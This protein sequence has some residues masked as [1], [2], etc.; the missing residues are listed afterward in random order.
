MMSLVKYSAWPLTNPATLSHMVPRPQFCTFPSLNNVQ[1]CTQPSLSSLKPLHISSVEKFGLS[2]NLGRRVTECRA[3]EADRSRPLELNIE[4]NGEGERIEATQRVKIGLYFATWWALNVVFN[5][6]NKKVLNAFP[7]PWLISTLSLAAGSLMMLISWA[8]RVA[9]VPKVN[10]EFWKALFP[11]AVAHTIGHVAATVSMSKVAVSFT[12]IIKSGEPAFS[13]LVSRFLLGEAFPV[14]VYLS[15]VPIIGGCAL[16]AVTELNFNMIGFM[17]AMISNLAFVF[18]NIFSKKGM[19]GMSVSGM[20]YYACLSILSLLILTPLAIAVEGPKLWAAGWQEALSQIGPNFVWWVAAQS[21]FYHLYNQVSYMSLDQISP[22]TFSI[23]NTMKRISVIVS[24][25]LIFHTPI[26]PVNALGAA[27]AILGTFLYSQEDNAMG[28]CGYK[29]GLV[30]EI[31]LFLF[32]CSLLPISLG[33]DPSPPFLFGTASSSYQYEGAYSSDGKGLSNWDVFSHTAGSIDDGSNGD[34]SVDQY[35]RYQE[36]IDLMEAMKVNSYRFSISWARILPQGRF[37]E[38]NLAGINYYNRLI[39]ALLLK[40]IQPF[41]TLFHFDI[42]QE[43]EDRYGAWLSPQSQEDFQFFADICFKFFGDRVKYWVTFNEPNYIIS[44]AYREGTFPPC[45]CSGIFGNCS[46]GDSE[47]EP[48]V[49]AHNMILSH[50]AAVDLYRNKYQNEQGGKI[51]IVL[52]CDSF[53]PLS[54]STSDKLATER[55]QSFSINWILDPILFGKYPKEMEMILGTIL[56]KFSSNDKVKLRRGLDFIGINHYASYYVRDCL[57]SVCG[58]GIGVSRTEGSYELTVL[59]N[60]VPIGELTPFEWLNVHPEGM[61]KIVIYLKDRYNN[62]PMFIAENGYGT[63][64]DPNVTEKEYL[65]DYKRIEFMS[66]HLD[67]LMAAIREGA[68]VRGYFVWSLLDNFEWKYGFTVR[69]GLYHVDFSTLKRTPKLSASWYKFFIEKYIAD[70][71]KRNILRK[72][73]EENNTSTS[74]PIQQ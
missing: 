12:H 22:L 57:S 24:S 74:Y 25:I 31:M 72:T 9:D 50:A 26:Q 21:V 27:I 42:P 67:N 4:L 52:H 36:D 70:N 18:R 62:T 61:K 46:E 56:P 48:F 59:K 8:T 60:G 34:V 66:G 55:A 10:L 41:V 40:G 51:G 53:E 44:L 11:V 23:G 37:G 30:L 2:A 33:L 58:H 69:F 19:K 43:L 28:F 6:Y 16:A 5:I 39:D 20:N 64:Y 65:N 17:G 47:K 45:R 38:V 7:Y 29:E 54:N 14:P 49:A 73:G 63:L 32:M 15:L 68:D 71:T 1:H 35:H 13:V 3:Y